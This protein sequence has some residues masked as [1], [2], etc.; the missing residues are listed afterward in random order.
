MPF[1]RSEVLYSEALA[2]EVPASLARSV[3]VEVW[4]E[5]CRFIGAKGQ[6][7]LRGIRNGRRLIG[8]GI[9]IDAITSI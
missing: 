6:R 1:T 9:E 5:V 3:V 8:V 4:E 2:S 7:E